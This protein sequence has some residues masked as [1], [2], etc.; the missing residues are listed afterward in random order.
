MHNP[1]YFTSE[2]SATQRGHVGL[3]IDSQTHRVL[4]R[5][6]LAY[7]TADLAE[8]AAKRLWEGRAATLATAAGLRS[9][10]A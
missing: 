9:E 6:S 8:L 5:T 3:V 1:V 7:A 10:V 2:P 4:L